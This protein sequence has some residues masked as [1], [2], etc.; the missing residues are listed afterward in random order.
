MKLVTRVISRSRE[1]YILKNEHGFWGIESS[2]F[3]DGRLTVQVNG[4]S[5]HLFPKVGDTIQSVLNRIEHE[6]LLASGVSQADA[7]AIMFKKITGR[8]MQK[9]SSEGEQMS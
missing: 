9:T 6:H 5:G 4:L 3:D 7:E 8:E 1:F 2:L